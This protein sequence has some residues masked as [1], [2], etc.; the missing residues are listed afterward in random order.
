[1]SDNRRLKAVVLGATGAVGQRFVELLSS[2]AWFEISRLSASERSAGKPY[3]EACRWRL[4]TPLPP[5]VAAAKVDDG[6][7]VPGI[8]VAFSALDAGVAGPIEMA[9][10]SAGVPVFSNARNH[11]LD[12]DVP[13][14]IPEINAEHLALVGRQRQA[15]GFTTGFIVTNPNCSATFLAMALGPLHQTFGVRRAAVVTLQAVSGAG[16]PGLPSMDI[17]G[18]VI[19]FIAGEEEKLEL[20]TLKI[21][22]LVDGGRVEPADFPI[23][24]QVNRVA[25]QDGHTE[26]V[27]F[28]LAQTVSV[29]EVRAALDTF[30]GDP[31]A[32]GLPSAPARPLLVLDEADR[33]QPLLDLYRERAMA[34]V[35]GRLRPCPV[36]GFKMTL[37]G[38]NTIRGAAG[39]SILNAELARARCLLGGCS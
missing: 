34:T 25:V 20:E 28:E 11:R 19:P 9:W 2:H 29:E 23:S 15:R 17:L 36:L 21:L 18:N 27:S 38:H 13:L 12:P 26:S 3:G 6:E 1:M 37:L 14:L 10:A 30:R 5:A 22:G 8:D 24:A 33:P 4:A 7:P 16:Y 35:I 32:L 31:Q 39:A